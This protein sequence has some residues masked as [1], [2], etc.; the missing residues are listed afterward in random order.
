MMPR[1]PMNS[2]SHFSRC[3]PLY[4][5]CV[6]AAI[7]LSSNATRSSAA[8]YEWVNVTV[9]AEFAPR[10]GAGGLSYQGKMWLIGG[11]NPGAAQKEFFPRICNNEVWNSTDGTKWSLAKPNSFK[12]QSF[13]PA[14]DW[15]GRHTAGYAVFRDRMWIIGGDANQGHYVHWTRH[16]EAAQ[17][18]P[19]QYH[20]VAA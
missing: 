10:H 5:S 16:T 17:W 3:V 4:F 12:D 2:I 7:L 8:D 13:D 20:D 9:N 19:R 1:R 18:A 15:E 11:W 14:T 6:V